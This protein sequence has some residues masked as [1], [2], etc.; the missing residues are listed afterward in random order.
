[1]SIYSMTGFARAEGQNDDS[2]WGWE[3]RSVNG[4]GLDVRLRL[5]S[6]FEALE[7]AVRGR[8]KQLLRRGNV[9]LSLSLT[10]THRPDAI[11][12]NQDMFDAIAALLP[13]LATKVPDAAPATLDGLLA[14]RGVLESAD[15]GFTDEQVKQLEPALMTDLDVALAGL[16]DMRAA[17]GGRLA[18]VLGEQMDAIEALTAEAAKLAATQPDAIAKRLKQQVEALLEDITALPADRLAQEAALLM[19]KAD[20]LEELD[21]LVAH[22][23]AARALLGSDAA[24]GRKLDFLCQEFNRE[25]NTLCSKST[26]VELTRVGLE[27]K[28]MIEQF[29]EQVQNIE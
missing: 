28:A 3:A 27:L 26:D 23:A 14:L 18:R 4:K 22:V 29:R 9:S 8:A 21:R 6:G 2:S 16:V 25:A 20:I 1:M 11:R 13:E 10:Q 5:P 7:Q 12:L 17:E 15:E 19:T 24:I